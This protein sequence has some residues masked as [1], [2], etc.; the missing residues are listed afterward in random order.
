MLKTHEEMQKEACLLVE[1]SLICS[2]VCSFVRSFIHSFIFGSGLLL[3]QVLYV[4]L[5][6]LELS[7]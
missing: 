1:V 4:A 7:L 3:S 6:V 5:D 2:L